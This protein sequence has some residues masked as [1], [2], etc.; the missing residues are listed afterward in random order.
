[1]RRLRMSRLVQLSVFCQFL[2]HFIRT[3]N[4]ALPF[5]DVFLL[6]MMKTSTPLFIEKIHLHLHWKS[7][8]QISW[9]RRTLKLLISRAYMVCSNETPLEKEL[10]HL[11]HVFHKI[12]GYPWWV[13]DQV[14]TSIQ[15]NIN[16]SKSSNYYPDTSEQP[17]KK[18]TL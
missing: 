2:I 7:F 8:T 6:E 12:N 3:W 16:K 13:I 9:E 1:M 18:C 10:K 11:K 4:N 15:Q 17:V 14:S 5:L